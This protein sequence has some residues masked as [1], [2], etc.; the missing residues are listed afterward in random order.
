MITIGGDDR[1]MNK[2]IMR[3]LVYYEKEK[4]GVRAGVMHTGAYIALQFFF[5]LRYFYLTNYLFIHLFIIKNV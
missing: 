4:I 5:L 2:R 3:K 1:A